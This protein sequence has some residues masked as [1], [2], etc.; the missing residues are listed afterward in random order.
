[1]NLRQNDRG[2]KPPDTKTR[3]L[4]QAL[5]SVVQLEADISCAK[6]LAITAA[7]PA[8]R[9]RFLDFIHNG[10]HLFAAKIDGAPR[11]RSAIT[12]V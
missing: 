6:L 9:E 11:W 10:N 7:R 4:Y 12:S 2:L 5:H 3:P 8:A 1:M